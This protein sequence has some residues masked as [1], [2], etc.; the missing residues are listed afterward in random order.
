MR[1]RS[2]DVSTLSKPGESRM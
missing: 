1:Q 2:E